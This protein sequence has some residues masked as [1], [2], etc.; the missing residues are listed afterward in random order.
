[1]LSHK[2]VFKQEFPEVA[3]DLKIHSHNDFETVAKYLT[4]THYFVDK[5]RYY[6]CEK[7]QGRCSTT[8]ESETPSYSVREDQ[9]T[10][11]NL[12]RLLE[13]SRTASMYS[14]RTETTQSWGLTKIIS[15]HNHGIVEHRYEDED[16]VGLFFETMKNTCSTLEKNQGCVFGHVEIEPEIIEQ[17]CLIEELEKMQDEEIIEIPIEEF[18][19]IDEVCAEIEN[20]VLLT[21]QG[22]SRTCE[23]DGNGHMECQDR[24]KKDT[25]NA[26]PVILSP[27]F[28]VYLSTVIL[29]DEDIISK[30]VKNSPYWEAFEKIIQ[31][32]VIRNP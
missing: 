13:N 12:K 20:K 15:N 26:N 21:V 11:S 23:F 30:I 10:P 5:I 32:Q 29:L 2:I 24:L 7:S 25:S 1:M 8:I 9:D 14:I 31:N 3:E 19:L 16:N 28:K 27:D 18:E 6:D 17:K 22:V 4:T